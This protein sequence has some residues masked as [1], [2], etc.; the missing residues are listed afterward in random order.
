M[1]LLG[2]TEG[3]RRRGLPRTRWLDDITDSMAMSLS[4]LQAIMKDREACCAAVHGAAKS[5]M[6]ERLNH[7]KVKEPDPTWSQVSLFPVKALLLSA[8]KEE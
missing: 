2:K 7:N 8:H 4:K 5:D 3:R 6:T 1:L